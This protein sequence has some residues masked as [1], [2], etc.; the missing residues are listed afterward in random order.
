MQNLTISANQ[1]KDMLIG[2]VS[3]LKNN[4]DI[5]NKLN[6]FPVP[7]GDTG[8]NMIKT[9]EGGI[10]LINNQ[11]FSTAGEVMSAFSKGAILGARGNSG[12]I[13]SQIFKGIEI[14]LH[15]LKT[16]SVS[17]IKNAFS[18]GVKL[19]YSAVEKPVEGTLLTVFRESTE[20]ANKNV[21]DTQS[22]E[23]YFEAHIEQ[24]NKTL[25][26]TKEMLPVLKD[27]DVIDSGGAGYKYIAEGMFAVLSG[28]EIVSTLNF[29][30]DNASNDLDFSK[31]TKDS[32]MVYGYC[33]EFMIR[34]QT[35]KVVDCDNFDVSI[36][37]NLLKSLGGDS[38]VA[39]KMDD[40]VKVHVHTFTPGVILNECQ[41]FGEFLTLKIENMTLQH[42]ETEPKKKKSPKKRLGVV[43]VVNGKGLKD[44]FYELGADY[45]I[46]G[47]QTTNPSTEDFVKAFE[48]VNAEQIIVLPDNSNVYLSAKQAGDVYNESEIYV[49]HTKTMQEGYVALS[50]VNTL[51]DDIDSQI[52]DINACI[53]EVDS[54]EITYSIRNATING[55]KVNEGQFM[56]I[57][58]GDIIAVGDDYLN[59]AINSIKN[60]KNFEEKEICTVFFGK[61][62]NQE[63][64]DK[65]ME[66]AEEEFPDY[67]FIYHNGE[68]DIYGFLISLE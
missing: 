51:I 6:V 63:L 33:T 53:S 49:I 36:I 13:L 16:I 20:Y 25:I 48:E 8:F 65:F 15:N 61:N 29:D 10:K 18:S 30:D 26:N 14:G 1:L 43:A 50:V 4:V 37:S 60:H 38:I 52:S 59:V 32:H 54:I 41:K 3:N 35:S 5:V 62:I 12:V 39:Y 23:E 64:R 22:V 46:D 42:S 67:E 40:I 7:D 9:I 28:K 11:D 17:D 21:L 19:S 56:A 47:G 58:S 66:T 27:A 24:L 2:G 44:L 55:V 68:Q 57:S 31:F 45:V 34:L